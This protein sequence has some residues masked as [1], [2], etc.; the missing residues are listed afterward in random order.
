MSGHPGEVVLRSFQLVV[1]SVLVLFAIC[2]SGQM[3]AQDSTDAAAR[4]SVRRMADGKQWTTVN[5]SVNIAPSYCYDDSESDCSRYGRLYTW[6]S[7]RRA[8][9][10]LGDGWRLPSDQEWRELAKHYGGIH[11]DSQDRGKR[12]Y[13]ALSRGGE[14][15]FEV[16]L[17]GG[18]AGDGKYARLEA[19]GFFWTASEI[20]AATAWYYNFGQGSQGLYRQN[21]GEKERAF[22]VRCVRRATIQ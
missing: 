10:S 3:S 12:A 16:L 8:C 22:S 11:D 17:G 6:E 21:G 9:E 7:A 4:Y 2:Y 19:H 5:L 18:R 14:S 20:D 13:T 1:L 15:R